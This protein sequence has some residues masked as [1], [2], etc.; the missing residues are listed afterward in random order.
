MLPH[1]FGYHHVAS[2][3]AVE[4]I[5][6]AGRFDCKIKFERQTW[7]VATEHHPEFPVLLILDQQGPLIQ[8]MKA[9]N[10]SDLQTVRVSPRR[11]Y[12]QDPNHKR[13]GNDDLHGVRLSLKPSVT[14]TC[15]EQNGDSA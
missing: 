2:A 6:A 13:G 5:H 3:N 4:P 9:P 8:R 7:A 15:G 12:R 10:A 11:E 1:I 14:V